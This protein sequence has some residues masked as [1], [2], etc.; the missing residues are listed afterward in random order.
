[1]IFRSALIGILLAMVIVS[2]LLFFPRREGGDSGLPPSLF[3]MF[4]SQNE[5]EPSRF[6]LPS[7]PFVKIERTPLKKEIAAGSSMRFVISV[8]N[9]SELTL[10]NLTI[11]ERFD[12]ALL[13]VKSV[14]QGT[15]GHNIILWKIPDMEPGE[16]FSGSYTFQVLPTTPPQ[17]IET[18]AFVRGEAIEESLSSSRMVTSVLTIISLP[19]TGADLLVSP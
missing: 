7:E 16:R 11:E 6:R 10:Q 13:S 9:M 5:E 4:P 8:K 1:M 17:T 12:D 18:T 19:K 2:G 3:P 14:E 15:L